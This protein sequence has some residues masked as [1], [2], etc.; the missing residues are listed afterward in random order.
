VGA[1]VATA[2]ASVAGADV[3]A[4][5]GAQAARIVAETTNKLISIQTYCFVF[6]L[7]ISLSEIWKADETQSDLSIAGAP[8]LSLLNKITRRKN[9]RL[10]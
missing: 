5:A 3:S 6:I 9:F 1:S 2:G 4:G 7:L 10:E 8:Q